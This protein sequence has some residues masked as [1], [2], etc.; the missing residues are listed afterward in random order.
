MKILK[1]FFLIGIYDPNIDA[2]WPWHFNYE[3]GRYLS[4]NKRVCSR[5]SSAEFESPE[6]ARLFYH[7]WKHSDKYKM[8][9]IE[10]KYWTEVPDPVYPPDHPRSIISL[11]IA[12]EKSTAR[13]LAVSWFYR[14]DT[15]EKMDYSKATR[16]RYC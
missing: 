1:S 11:V 4:A 14:L 10:T 12:N 5:N 8:E 15:F 3:N 9:V 2:A 7:S 13:I 6:D 16:E